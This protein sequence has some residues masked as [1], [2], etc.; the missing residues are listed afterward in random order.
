MRILAFVPLGPPYAGPEVSNSI[1][2]K[3]CPYELIKINTSFQRNNADKGKITLRAILSYLRNIL[4]L[5]WALFR[6][7]PEVF[8]YNISATPLGAIKDFVVISLARPFVWRVVAHMRGGHFGR[9]YRSANPI[10]KLLVR[11]YL[12][13]CDRLI[14]QSESLKEQF[15]NIFP[16]S[17]IFVVPNPASGEFFNLKPNLKGKNILF[18]GHLSK[19][20][21]WTD[22]LK[23][24]PEVLKI[25]QD[26]R[27][28]AVGSKIKKETN[29]LWL[30]NEDP[31][32][33]F[34]EYIRKNHLEDRFE[35]YENIYRKEKVEIF[36]RA[37]LFVLPSYSEGFPMAVLEAMA[38]G[39]PVIS[40]NVGAIPEFLPKENPILEPGDLEGLK[41]AILKLLN[42][43]S[44]RLK[45]SKINRE[46]AREFEE[47]KVRKRF[48]EVIIGR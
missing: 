4:R 1:L 16:E 15:F 22:L 37:S 41:G 46:K 43:E 31:D 45:L 7:R 36:K 21:G 10:I 5:I 24:L 40:T 32:E 6:F 48:W 28:I 38:C 9:F 18:V 17:R 29:I 2:L 30:K 12:L 26:A 3:D 19:A 34:E 35:F 44:L 39:L 25:H 14:V 23:V 47:D 27:V 13:K 8:Y 33:V 11:W 20:K 42:D